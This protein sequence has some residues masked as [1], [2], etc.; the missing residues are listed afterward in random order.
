MNP[1][2]EFDIAVETAAAARKKDLTAAK[3]KCERLYD[4]SQGIY[5]KAT[6]DWRDEVAQVEELYEQAITEARMKFRAR[7]ED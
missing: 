6:D 1:H 2:V 4:L 3:E 5:Q 7:L